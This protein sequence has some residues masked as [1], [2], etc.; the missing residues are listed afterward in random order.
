VDAGDGGWG[1][2]IRGVGGEEEALWEGAVQWQR[3]R[4][5]QLLNRQLSLVCRLRGSVSTTADRGTAALA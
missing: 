3:W 2:P 1:R 5:R 4:R